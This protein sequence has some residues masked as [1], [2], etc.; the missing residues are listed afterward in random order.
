MN[1]NGVPQRVREQTSNK[2]PVL[3]LIYHVCK[4]R[5]RQLRQD[6]KYILEVQAKMEINTRILKCNK[7]NCERE[8][9]SFDQ[10]K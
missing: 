9:A 8:V 3:E 4:Y 1:K 7:R 6:K 2:E 5:F 10:R